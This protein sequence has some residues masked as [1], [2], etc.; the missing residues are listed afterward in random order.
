ML[1][2]LKS[3][4]RSISSSDENSLPVQQ[5]HSDRIEDGFLLV[6]QT[7]SERTTVY[8]DR[9]NKNVGAPPQYGEIRQHEEF[10]PSYKEYTSNSVQYSPNPTPPQGQD[11]N[12][13]EDRQMDQMN[14]LVPSS[15]SAIADVPF[16]LACDTGILNSLQ[17]LKGGFFLWQNHFCV[18]KYDYDFAVELSYLKEFGGGIHVQDKKYCENLHDRSLVQF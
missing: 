10:L 4:T 9:F 15:K 16:V 1:S 14:L 18:E 2:F 12:F 3:I 7:R 11:T 6:G 13:C 17:E 5:S 8:T